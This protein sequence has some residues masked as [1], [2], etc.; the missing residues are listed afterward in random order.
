[1]VRLVRETEK[2]E[3]L[4]PLQSLSDAR[5]GIIEAIAHIKPDRMCKYLEIAI[6]LLNHVQADVLYNKKRD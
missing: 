2:Q 3:I 4:D 6:T 1:M 5:Q